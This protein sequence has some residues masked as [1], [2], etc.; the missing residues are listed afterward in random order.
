MTRTVATK[1]AGVAGRVLRVRRASWS[2]IMVDRE[3]SKVGKG[4][5]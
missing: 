4:E 2:L 1:A 5:V 3:L